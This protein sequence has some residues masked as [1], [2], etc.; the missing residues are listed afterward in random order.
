MNSKD[1]K[2]IVEWNNFNLVVKRDI[3]FDNLIT[4]CEF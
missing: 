1:F 3:N 2:L 4:E